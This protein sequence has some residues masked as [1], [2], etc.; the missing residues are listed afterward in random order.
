[1]NNTEFL[2]WRY[3]CVRVFFKSLRKENI[4]KMQFFSSKK[5]NK[6][7]SAIALT[8]A[9]ASVANAT[10]ITWTA[11]LSFT[12]RSGSIQS[13][14]NTLTGKF[15]YDADTGIVTNHNLILSFQ[16]L[17]TVPRSHYQMEFTPNWAGLGTGY[18]GFFIQNNELVFNLPDLSGISGNRLAFQFN[19][20]T[21][22]GGEL[23]PMGLKKISNSRIIISAF[24]GTLAGVS[25]TVV[26]PVPEPKG[27][28]M[29]L[30]GLGLIGFA[31]RR[32]KYR[33]M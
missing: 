14:Q 4:I 26:S 7:L 9:F 18:G 13:Y 22:S 27:Y 11:D 23:S 6:L 20:L 31:A 32:K 21:N 10:P 5:V 12:S 1:M 2:Y 3:F 28:A 17:S 29:M 33:L 24:G 15:T 19:S 8:F 25:P 16:A 30:V